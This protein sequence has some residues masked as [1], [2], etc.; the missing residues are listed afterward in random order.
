MVQI[1]T[2][3]GTQIAL[4]SVAARERLCDDER[5]GTIEGV[6]IMQD[7]TLDRVSRMLGEQKSRR[8]VFRL[9]G[10]TVAGGFVAA[11]GFR[12]VTAAKPGTGSGL[13]TTVT[14][15]VNGV[16]QDLTVAV[17]QFLD[18]AGTLS[19]VGNI[20]SSVGN[21][22]GTFTTAVTATGTCDILNLVLAPIHLDLLGLVIDIP[23]P[24]VLNITA[25]QGPGN[26]LGNLLCAVT[27]LLDNGGPLQG[28]VGLL[29][30]ILRAL[31]R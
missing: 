29:N 21:L 6:S 23:N 24:I 2:L 5:G 11:A 14:G 26:L 7:N 4:C 8:Q 10:G 9:V 13:A 16:T 19:A 27:H 18:A 28:I 22:L 17:T 20:L 31:G 12:S 3:R 30:N 25:E 1:P 15:T